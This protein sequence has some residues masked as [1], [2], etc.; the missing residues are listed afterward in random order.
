MQ[1]QLKKGV[2][3][4]LVLALLTET[5]RYGYD[6]VVAISEHVEIS[7][8]TIYPLLSR[9][10]KEKYVDTYLKESSN[11]PSRKYYTITKEGNKAYGEMKR[12]WQ[13]FVTVVNNMLEGVDTHE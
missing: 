1:I 2:M 4:L 8:G 13:E 6:M 10:K 5:D 9:L 7:E 3:E 12:E 11:G